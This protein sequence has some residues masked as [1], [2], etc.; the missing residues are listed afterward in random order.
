VG[1]LCDGPVGCGPAQRGVG[2]AIA[3]LAGDPALLTLTGRTLSVDELATRY[4][5]DVTS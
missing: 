3:A 5:I 2:R 4:R 1:R